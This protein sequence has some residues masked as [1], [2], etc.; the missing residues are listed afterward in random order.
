MPNLSAIHR[1]KGRTFYQNAINEGIWGVQGGFRH[2]TE[3]MDQS[4]EVDVDGEVKCRGM[5][6]KRL[7]KEL[8]ELKGR[9]DDLAIS[10]VIRHRPRDFTGGVVMGGK[11][12]VDDFF[13]GWRERFGA[14]RKNGAQK[15]RGALGE[16]AGAI[17]SARDLR[18]GVG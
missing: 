9:K 7:E 18:S 13:Q 3:A 1:T 5:K 15:P 17:W 10:R 14:R 4:L 6:R 11:E 2:G 8:A 16:L 12:F